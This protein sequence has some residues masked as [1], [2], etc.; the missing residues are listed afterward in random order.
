M[1]KK[2]MIPLFATFICW[3]SVYAVSKVA[4]RTIPPVT[5]LLC[6]YVVAVPTL[7]LL[8]KLRG[9]L[10]P[11]EGKDR[12]TILA[13]GFLGYFFSFCLQMLGIS[14]LSGSVS[15]LLGAMNP[16]FIPLL[17]AIFLR[18]EMTL[19][20]VACVALSMTGVAVIVGVG[21]TADPL[22]VVLMLLSV[23]LWSSTSIIIRRLGGRYDPMQVAMMAIACAIPLTG[24]WSAY[25]LASNPVSFPLPSVLAVLFMGTIGT[26]APHSLW[27][28]CLSK[29]DASFCSMFYPLQP[30][31][32]STLGVIFLG[33][34]ITVNYLLG[35]AIICCGIIAAVRTARSR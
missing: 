5:L 19:R 34:R 31:V 12:P 35:A 21:G 32:A 26:A 28:Y 6:R 15:S 33:E 3:G 2:H 14:R 4:L 13:I 10:R 25:E 7:L 27:N 30:L 16:I 22:G 24:A 9:A 17:A 29:M 20:K 1:N 23:F 8:L 18:E 11:L